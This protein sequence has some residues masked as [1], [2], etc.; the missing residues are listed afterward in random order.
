MNEFWVFSLYPELFD[1]FLQS[2]LLGRAIEEEKI[3]VK[4]FNFREYGL[5]KHHKVDDTPY[6]GGAGMLLR[7]EP[8]IESLEVADASSVIP[9]HRVL[10]TPR[11]KR[12]TQQDARRLAGLDKPLALVCGR[13]EG[14]DERIYQ[15]VDEEFSLGDF[16]LMGGEVAAMAI[17][18]SVARLIPDVIGNLDSTQSESFESGLLEYAQYTKPPV[19]RGLEVPEVLKSGD[20]QKI[21]QWRLENSRQTTRTKRPDLL[22]DRPE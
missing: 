3:Q 1:S 9:A 8:L 6:G 15:F 20:H 14:F 13:F 4:R 16:V 19:Y 10:I 7:P 21:A 12:L 11:A 18:E 5:G 17:I 22:T 2:G